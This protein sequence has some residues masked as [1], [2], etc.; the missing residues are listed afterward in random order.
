MDDSSIIALYWERSDRAI[1]ET[2]NKYGAYC[3]YIANAILPCHEDAEECVND[4]WLRTW[5]AIPPQ[6]PERLQT[7][8]GKITRNLA[9][10]RWEKNR[11]QKRGTGQAFLA[12]EEL[13]ECIGDGSGEE[14]MADELHIREVL[15]RFLAGL[16][17][18]TRKIF[19]RRYWYMSPVKE[20]AAEYGISESKVSVTLFRTRNQLKAVLEKEGIL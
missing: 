9:L 17:A 5:N 14:R 6:R 2:A 11:A 13:A 1:A 4:T 16:P 8:L 19:V 18:R 15:N 3:H 12:L 7:F 10:N 20:I